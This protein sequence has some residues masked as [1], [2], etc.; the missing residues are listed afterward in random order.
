MT[1]FP[2]SQRS[3][4]IKMQQISNLHIFLHSGLFNLISLN[5]LNQMY[6]IEHCFRSIFEILLKFSVKLTQIIA[7][8]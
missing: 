6:I 3:T 7:I 4:T 8:F 2:T 5:K 1:L